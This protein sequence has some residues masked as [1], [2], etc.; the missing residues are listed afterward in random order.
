LKTPAKSLVWLQALLA[1]FF[2]AG[3]AAVDRYGPQVSFDSLYYANAAEY[4]IRGQ[5]FSTL[6]WGFVDPDTHYAPLY[7]LLLAGF[8]WLSTTSPLDLGWLMYLNAALNIW[9]FA[10]LGRHFSLSFWQQLLWP[11]L[12]ALS[13]AFLQVHTSFWSEPLYLSFLLLAFDQLLRPQTR[14]RVWLLA[15]IT[16]MAVLVRFAGL[17]VLPFFAVWLWLKADGRQQ[18]RQHFWTYIAL[19]I[20]PF[21]MWT[22]RN[23]WVANQLSSRRLF[24]T[25]EPA[26]FVLGIEE[27]MKWPA[28]VLLILAGILLQ[29]LVAKKQVWRQLHWS[30]MLIYPFIFILWLM[31]AKW[32]ADPVIPFDGRMLSPVLPFF[33]VYTYWLWQEKALAKWSVP[34]LATA[35]LLGGW[36]SSHFLNQ[37]YVQGFGYG[38]KE[39]RID[40]GP[41]QVF[42]QQA[43]Q[44][45]QVYTTA[46]EQLMWSYWLKMP[47]QRF[48]YAT[49]LPDSFY[50]L[51]Y[52]EAFSFEMP[53]VPVNMD[54]LLPGRIWK[55]Y[56][57]KSHNIAE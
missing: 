22:A 42:L 34:L 41:A 17:F 29:R 10:R 25:F 7:A 54:T 40:T 49:A 20:L 23:K 1:V 43:E 27:F 26:D 38:R 14:R 31:L 30:W 28:W 32:L 56:P 36:A 13:L 2:A 24:W 50:L 53:E 51:R 8:S 39:M 44:G 9:L 55:V 19:S 46:E 52:P 6:R 16:G 11:L 4:L 48:E 12:F 45:V 21:L 35:I 15:F 33:G 3:L 57:L 47:V 18:A 37:I 5:G